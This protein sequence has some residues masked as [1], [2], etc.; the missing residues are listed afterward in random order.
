[1]ITYKDYKK[2]MNTA[3]SE[4]KKAN[5]IDE[6]EPEAIFIDAFTTAFN[7]DKIPSKETMEEILF[8]ALN[9]DSQAVEDAI[10]NIEKYYFE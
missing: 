7:I 1:M 8:V 9:G 4:Y 2:Q 3:L 10:R 5:D 6:Q